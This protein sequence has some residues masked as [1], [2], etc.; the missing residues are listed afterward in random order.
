MEW[1][2]EEDGE[3]SYFLKIDYITACSFDDAGEGGE[4]AGVIS[5]EEREWCPVNIWMIWL[6][7]GAQTLHPGGKA[8][9]MGTHSGWQ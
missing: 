7:K 6:Q 4:T 3:S 5:L 1:Q 2:L 8:N 9:Y